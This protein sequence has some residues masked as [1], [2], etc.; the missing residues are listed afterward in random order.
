LVL[1]AV[2]GPLALVARDT[3]YPVA[4]FTAFHETAMLPSLLFA[5]AATPVGTTGG[6]QTAEPPL[7]PDAP[8]PASLP[9]DP[10]V[11][12]APP[13]GI[14]RPAIVTPVRQNEK[15]VGAVPLP[16]AY[17]AIVL[18]GVPTLRK[19]PLLSQHFV[20]KLVIGIG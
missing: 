13:S 2:N 9:L 6:V 5:L 20:L 1:T 3:V 15:G 12:P 7:P 18:I 10:P 17:I 8:A 19:V 11:P 16:Y 14:A 4:A